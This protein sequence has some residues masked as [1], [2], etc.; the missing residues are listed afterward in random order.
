MRDRAS[1]CSGRQ[2]LYEPFFA[3]DPVR[4]ADRLYEQY[5]KA[6][7]IQR[8]HDLLDDLEARMLDAPDGPAFGDRPAAKR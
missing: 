8:I 6:R 3:A 1:S 2:Q 4:T 7:H 5:D